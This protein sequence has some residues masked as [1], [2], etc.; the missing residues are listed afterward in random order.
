MNNAF[1]LYKLDLKNIFIG[2]FFTLFLVSCNTSES[3][4]EVYKI[5]FA[6]A[7]TTDNWRRDMNK[8]M[9][10]EASMHPELSLKIKDANNDVQRQIKQIEGFI[11]DGVDVLIVSPIQSVPITPAIE[12]AMNTGIPVI[13]IDRKIQNSNYTAYLGADNF[14]IGN[15]AA[16]YIITSKSSEIVHIVE[17]TGDPGSS[18]AQERTHGFNNGINSKSNFTVTQQI[19]GNW[20]KKS[21]ITKLT[22]L[23]DTIA[24]PDFIFAHNDRMALGAWEVAKKKKI[25]SQIKIIGVDGLFGPNGGIQLVKEGIL[26]ATILYPTGGAEAM[27]LS[28]R[29]LDGESVSK[30][31]ILKSVVI[32]SVNVDI[33]QNQFDK[34]NQQQNDIALQQGVINQQIDTYN[35]QNNLIKIMLCLLCILLILVIGTIYLVYRLKKSKHH[36]ERNNQQII[37]QRNQI[38]NFAKKLEKYNEE[39][40]NFF[41]SLSHEFKTPLTLI[42]SSIES[43]AT[44]TGTGLQGYEYER[45]LI[46]NNSKRLLRLINE[47]LDFRKLDANSFSPK[48]VKTNLKQFLEVIYE[49]F[50]NEALRKPINFE[51]TTN[52]K[53][54]I[55]YIDRLMMDKVF[56]NILSNAFKFTPQ[57]GNI[58]ITITE[59][60]ETYEVSVK[61][62]GIG[63]P[64]EEYEKIFNPFTQAKN[65]TK[66]SSGLGLYITR[67]FVEL[68]KGQISVNS[69]KGTE[70]KITLLKGKKHL[71]EFELSEFSEIT[72]CDHQVL[73]F[74]SD[75]EIIDS[76]I[77]V[78]EQA[79]HILIIE[80]NTD[81]SQLLI[82][83]LGQDY[84]VHLSDGTQALQKA[85]QIIPDIII[86][87]INLPERSGFELCKNLKTDLR[88]SHIPILILTALSD[89][90]SRIKALQA[91]ADIYLTKPFIFD[92]LEKS[93]SSLLYNREKLR[94]Y[95]TH[96]LGEVKDEKFD[97]SEQHF[98]KDLNTYIE[99]N[100]NNPSFS[101]E[102]LAKQLHI[103]RV[104]LYRKVKALLGISVSEYINT[105]RLEKAKYLLQTS[106]LNISEIAYQL[107]YSSP[108]YFST[109]FKNKYGV[110]PRIF[111]K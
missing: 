106:T 64:K 18:P 86:C 48:P 3:R 28:K 70:F 42:T 79:E 32:D 101:V 36:L 46:L 2:V 60:D 12:K 103:S 17:I 40:I 25:N 7:M 75:F 89:Q 81:L 61:D 9:Q 53:K 35:S 69:H 10:V 95:Y 26:S 21:V 13:V 93:I 73:E 68:H 62:S 4:E 109:T 51:F 97:S 100:L 29:I 85:F 76:P 43:I 22:N 41:T 102:D 88:T 45:K 33:M 92:V 82:R 15:Q 74:T 31:N 94:Y 23:L 11:N 108:G 58:R 49:D 38:E 71:E 65:N 8:S 90:A 98:L 30:N 63:I 54:P 59:T 91:G 110:S 111:K 105:Q 77:P 34:I 84:F 66:N 19:N 14:D 67:K 52:V 57:N 72:D 1:F 5:G 83:K 96:K 6:Q 78:D 47:L 80:D 50:N 37:S 56:F 27:K 20:E 39:K 44:K 99:A 16:K 55:V 87:D 104:Q 24:P 107:G